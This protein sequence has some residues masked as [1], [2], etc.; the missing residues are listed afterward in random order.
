MSTTSLRVPFAAP[1]A[2]AVRSLGLG[3][4]V[5]GGHL[6]VLLAVAE[7][8]HGRSPRAMYEWWLAAVVLLAVG[9]VLASGGSGHLQGI[10]RQALGVDGGVAGV[11]L[12]QVAA[13]AVGLD[14]MRR[15]V[16][17]PKSAAAFAVLTACVGV[18]YHA[19]GS[20][21]LVESPPP[22]LDGRWWPNLLIATLLAG[23]VATI[24]L[25]LPDVF[26]LSRYPMFSSPRFD[27]YVVERVRFLVADGPDA[28]RQ[29]PLP[30]SR[31]VLLDLASRGDGELR[32]LAAGL[33]DKHDVGAVRAVIEEA[34][35][36]PHPAPPATEFIAVR[37]VLGRAD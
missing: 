10:L 28:G 5:F 31:L 26:P 25:Q 15:G 30:A 11:A 36:L 29:L 1:A 12:A 32:A 6:L 13:I 27:P 14:F 34:R 35:L 33:A 23:S 24:G 7:L 20:R 9:W 17:S 16:V 19:V 21:H 37:E 8:R 4:L 18:A 22:S 2:R 3:L